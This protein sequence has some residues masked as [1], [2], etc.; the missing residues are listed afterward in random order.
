MLAAWTAMYMH[1]ARL[2]H[3]ECVWQKQGRESWTHD[4]MRNSIAV[5][6]A[7]G[8]QGNGG[9]LWFGD[10]SSSLPRAVRTSGTTAKARLP[11]CSPR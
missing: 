3:C 7:V 5:A 9:L 8:R 4:A 2:V 11:L 10:L 6:A 1:S